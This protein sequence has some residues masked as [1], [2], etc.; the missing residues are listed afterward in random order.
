MRAFSKNKTWVIQERLN[1]LKHLADYTLWHNAIEV[2]AADHVE[3]ELEIYNY[4]RQEAELNL[5][6]DVNES[7]PQYSK[8]AILDK[9]LNFLQ[10]HHPKLQ[11]LES[12]PE[13]YVFRWHRI[14]EDAEAHV[15][16]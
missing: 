11:G 1:G 5:L 10:D 3:T 9:Y 4:R 13:T 12:D 15:Q 6:L 7:Y 14:A 16:K 2:V 8:A